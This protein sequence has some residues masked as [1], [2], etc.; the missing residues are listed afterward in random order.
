[1]AGVVIVVCI[2]V[3]FVRNYLK[4]E[5]E[6]EYGGI[7]SLLQEGALPALAT[8]VVRPRCTSTYSNAQAHP[9]GFVQ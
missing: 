5:D 8:F 1:M 2:N 6:D 7:L 3:W 4:L 9:I